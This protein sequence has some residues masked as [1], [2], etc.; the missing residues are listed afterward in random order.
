MVTGAVSPFSET[1][2]P[3]PADTALIYVYRRAGITP[4]PVRIL[5]NGKVVAELN[6]WQFAAISWTDKRQEVTLCLEDI[7]GRCTAFI[8]EFGRTA[9]VGITRNPTYSA[10]P[11]L[12]QA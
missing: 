1:N 2:G 10:K 8:P 7:P 4:K 5:F 12:E 11:A 9:Y 6:E 3:A